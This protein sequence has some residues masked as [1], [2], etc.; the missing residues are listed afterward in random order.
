MKVT[1]TAS[2]PGLVQGARLDGDATNVAEGSSTPRKGRSGADPFV[3]ALA[4]QHD[5]IVVT[6]ETPAGLNARSPKIPDVCNERDVA[7]INL[8]GLIQREKWVF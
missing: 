5:A 1:A 8:L 7:W 4:E 2:N 3:I 6:Q